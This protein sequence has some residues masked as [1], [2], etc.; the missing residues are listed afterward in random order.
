MH[1]DS[2]VNKQGVT[3][4]DVMKNN[5]MNTMEDNVVNGTEDNVVNDME[6]NVVNDTEDNVV[7]DTE[8]NVVNDTEDN[9]M[10]DM[11]NDVVKDIVGEVLNDVDNVMG[12]PDG[13]INKQVKGKKR[14]LL[15]VSL[16]NKYLSC[17]NVKMVQD[18]L[19]AEV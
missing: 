18:Q 11:E 1:N 8:D 14:K 4:N 9:V 16:D 13:V 6:D 5:V 2:I 10:N 19:E 7:N 17:M 12:K 3:E 15:K